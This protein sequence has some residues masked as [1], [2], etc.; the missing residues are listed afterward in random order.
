MLAPATWSGATFLGTAPKPVSQV[1][2]MKRV[3]LY[4]QHDMFSLKFIM[5]CS[6][7]AG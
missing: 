5:N 1:S 3:K 4:K 6:A 2:I 7:F